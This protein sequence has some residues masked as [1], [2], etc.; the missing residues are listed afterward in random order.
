MSIDDFNPYEEL[1]L[2]IDATP[3]DIRYAY[4]RQ[5]LRFHPD[6]QEGDD[7]KFKR[8]NQAYQILID[9]FQKELYDAKYKNKTSEENAKILEEFL[10]NVVTVLHD[11]LK[12]KLN[13]KIDSC[14]TKKENK[15]KTVDTSDETSVEQ[16]PLK[17]ELD[18]D[19]KDVYNANV[20]K[21][22]IK[23]RNQ[24]KDILK[25]FYLPLCDYQDIYCFEGDGDNGGDIHIKLNIVSNIMPHIKQDSLVS[26]YNL[27]IETYLTLYEYYFGVERSIPFYDE[28]ILINLSPFVTSD[29][30]HSN[31][32]HFVHI[33]NNKGLPY[34]N[35]NDEQMRGDL[36]IHFTLMLPQLCADG[37]FNCQPMLKTF[38]HGKNE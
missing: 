11:K 13:S 9:P 14:N 24:D 22:V 1:G 6:K 7:M 20:K 18:V 28:N 33:I 17:I 19:I 27:Y 35:E 37:L 15:E 16:A 5:A 30:G 31:E 2:N 32:T 12:E 3:Q 34:M 38:F 10:S 23:V 25:P 26:K 21:V 29:G 36:F 4:K 8:V